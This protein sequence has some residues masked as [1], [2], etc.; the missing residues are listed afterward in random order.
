MAHYDAL[1]GLPNRVLLHQRLGD[2]LAHIARSG[3]NLAAIRD[4]V[5]RDRFDLHYQPLFEMSER[6]LIGFEALIRLSAEDGTLIP[7]L[8]FIP[9]AEDLRL[10]EK[11]GAWVLREACRTARTWPEHV[12]VAVN[13]SAAQ[14]SASSV[15]DIVAAALKEAGLAAHRLELEITET[16][17]LDNSEA[18]IEELHTL[19]AMGVGIVMDDFG[20]GHSSLR[21]LWRFPFDKIKIDRSLMQRFDGSDRYAEAVVKTIIALGRE[22]HMRVMVEGVETAEQAAFLNKF[23]GAQAQGFFFGRPVPASEVAANILSNFQQQQTRTLEAEAKL[24]LVK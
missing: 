1:T 6:R 11:I 10:I 22:L 15:S 20:T 9:V 8:A 17:L 12:T 7:P 5:L 2:S 23:D 21:Y 13:L 24:R 18:I 19:K 16:L 14:F 3:G 4:A